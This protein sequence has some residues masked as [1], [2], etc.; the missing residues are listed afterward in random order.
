MTQT[1]SMFSKVDLETQRR[2]A[3]AKVYSL[4]IK[5]AEDSEESPTTEEKAVEP[6]S[7]NPEPL[8][9]NIPVGQ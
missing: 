2:K 4:L 5:L 9:L 1:S 6:A 7:T 8:K 3:L